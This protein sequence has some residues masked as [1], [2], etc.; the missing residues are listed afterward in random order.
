MG[1]H[2]SSVYWAIA[3]L[4]VMSF[5]INSF[6][7][8][9]GDVLHKIGLKLNLPDSVRG[10]TFDA[11]SSSVSEL[12]TAL[13]AVLFYQRFADIGFATIAG[14]G[15]F[16]IL[17]IP[18]LSLIFFK[19]PKGMSESELVIDKK[20]VRRD[21]FFYLGCLAILIGSFLTGSLSW[22]TGAILISWY[23][24]YIFVL[25][26]ETKAHQASADSCEVVEDSYWKLFSWTLV[27]LAI[28]W[29]CID[30]IIVSAVYISDTL[31]IPQFI[32]SLIVLAA[33]TSIPDTLLSINSARRGDLEGSISNAVG[34]NIFDISVCLGLPLLLFWKP[35]EVSFG[36]N[37][38]LFGFLI[39]SMLLTAGV[40]LIR[41]HLKRRDA[42]FLF[43]G[44]LVFLGYIV[45]RAI[46]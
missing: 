40:L 16:N 30:N 9:L 27:S 38:V 2:V 46:G 29:F 32:V 14:S 28:I 43:I 34:S 25:Y 23:C 19:L 4:L 3:A 31:G 37:W 10:A 15:V 24:V 33:C 41:K 39:L 5:I 20:S 11:V 8:T 1:I 42:W 35:I 44:Y 22:I 13:I 45:I 36:T 6:A 7:D 26:K 12:A 18:M 17:L 21:A